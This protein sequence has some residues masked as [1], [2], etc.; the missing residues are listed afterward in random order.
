MASRR[1][2][3]PP[4]SVVGVSLP[5][6]TIGYYAKVVIVEVVIVE[7]SQ[8]DLATSQKTVNKFSSKSALVAT[9]PA[10]TTCMWHWPDASAPRVG[11]SAEAA[12]T[13]AGEASNITASSCA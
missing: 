7:V 12:T 4:L 13:P 8:R 1:E 2:S 9:A 11:L 3:R 10:T 6:L 5:A